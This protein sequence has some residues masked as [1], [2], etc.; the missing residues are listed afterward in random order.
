M[1]V[2]VVV[3]VMV[4]VVVQE[5]ARG[6]QGGRGAADVGHREDGEREGRV[7][8]GGVV[9]GRTGRVAEEAA[10]GEERKEGA[11]HARLDH[12]EHGEGLLRLLGLLRMGVDRLDAVVQDVQVDAR[13]QRDEH[14]LAGGGEPPVV[15]MVTG[16]HGHS[17]HSHCEQS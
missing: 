13:E 16:K 12:L 2:V 9:T 15:S 6:G 1:V 5:E 10:E 7:E 14:A 8:E 4:M 11:L 17:K 3:V